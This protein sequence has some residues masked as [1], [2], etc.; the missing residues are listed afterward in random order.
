MFLFNVSQE[1]SPIQCFSFPC[2]VS[3]LFSNYRKDMFKG[4]HTWKEQ[5]LSLHSLP[6]P[7]ISLNSTLSEHRPLQFAEHLHTQNP[8]WSSKCYSER[9]KCANP[10]VETEAGR[11]QGVCL[12]SHDQLLVERD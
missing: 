1:C 5:T 7:R 11:S 9:N 12:K 2:N 8:T 4:F 3:F 10:H 6:T